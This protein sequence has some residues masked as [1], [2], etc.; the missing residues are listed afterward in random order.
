M[1][2][3]IDLQLQH[4]SIRK[5]KKEALSEEIVS[6]L[7]KAGQHAATSN[8]AQ[9]YSIISITDPKKKKAIAEIG[10]QAHI[11]E[12]GHLF[13]MLAD[14]S[15]NASIVAKQGG[16]TNIFSSF[17]KFF[18]GATDA[19]LAAQNIIIAAESLGLGGVI[20]GCILNQVDELST[21]LKLPPLVVPVLGIS[22]GYPDQEPQLKPR[23]PEDLIHFENSYPQKDNI[24]A[25][26]E[27][28]DNTVTEYYSARDSNKRFETFAQ[29][30][31]DWS[32]Q[33]NP[34]RLKMLGNIQKQDMA[35]F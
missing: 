6:K 27:E 20:L 13:I 22:L 34:G 17:D 14:Q 2:S 4:R 5:F 35:K 21:L 33:T 29:M 18:I 11:A 9:S 16:S 31:T 30:V 24:S 12:S 3:V 32:L 26:L 10:Q 8:Y 1:N 25:Q 15:R 7:V 28:Y 23:M 19:I